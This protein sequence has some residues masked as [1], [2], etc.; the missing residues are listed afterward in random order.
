MSCLFFTRCLR[1]AEYFGVVI[2]SAFWGRI[3]DFIGVRRVYL[4]LL[5]LDTGLFFM[6]ALARSAVELLIL[7]SA[8]GFCAIMPIGTAWVAATAPPE[9][10]MLAFALVV[11]SILGGFISGSGAISSHSVR[12]ECCLCYPEWCRT[13]AAPFPSG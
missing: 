13:F 3:A 1:F 12:G 6:S 5:A 7:R 8:A 9:K 10:Q 4:V 11:A 2:G